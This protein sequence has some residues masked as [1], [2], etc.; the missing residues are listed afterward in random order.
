MGAFMSVQ[1]GHIG[2]HFVTCRTLV[3]LIRVDFLNVTVELSPSGEAQ[4]T[5]QTVE[6]LTGSM[7][8]LQ[9]GS[10]LAGLA[11]G[12][13]T[14]ATG[15]GSV[16]CVSAHVPG[17]LN[18]LGKSSFAI[19]THILVSLGVFLLDMV[20]QACS[21]SEAH[22]TLL[23]AIRPFSCVEPDM[24]L[25]GLFGRKP[26]TTFGTRKWFLFKMLTPHV[27]CQS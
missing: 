12:F 23:T 22:V 25:Q 21:G 14:L 1:K 24:G 2:E 17:Q 10:Q 16:S 18:G 5:F 13:P 15:I 9:V 27:V 4:R 3:E 20:G 26:C 11:E 8:G 7:C 6:R 19:L